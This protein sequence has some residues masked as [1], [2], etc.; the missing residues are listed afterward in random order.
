MNTILCFLSHNNCHKWRMRYKKNDLTSLT[1]GLDEQLKA[2]TIFY[3]Y[4]DVL[5][6]DGK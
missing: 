5:L 1:R 6:P 4:S 2:Y 3:R